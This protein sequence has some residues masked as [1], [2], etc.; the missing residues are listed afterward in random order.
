MP[1]YNLRHMQ[2]QPNAAHGPHGYLLSTIEHILHASR[3]GI[4]MDPRGIIKYREEIPPKPLVALENDADKSNEDINIVPKADSLGELKEEKLIDEENKTAIENNQLTT[5]ENQLHKVEDHPTAGRMKP[6]TEEKETAT[7]EHRPKQTLKRKLK[8]CIKHIFQRTKARKEYKD[9]TGTD[10]HENNIN[11]KEKNIEIK[12][13]PAL[14]QTRDSKVVPKLEVIPEQS[15]EP[16]IGPNKREASVQK[17]V[18]IKETIDEGGRMSEKE[19]MTEEFQSEDHRAE[20]MT[21][22]QTKTPNLDLERRV[23]R[24]LTGDEL[25]AKKLSLD[26]DTSLLIT[27][28]SMVQMSVNIQLKDKDAKTRYG[29][30]YVPD[31]LECLEVYYDDSFIGGSC[32]KINPADEYSSDHRQIRLFHCDFQCEHSLIVCVVTKNLVGYEEQFLNVKLHM[33]DESGE[34]LQVILIGRDVSQ[35][36]SGRGSGVISHVAPVNTAA[37]EDFRD[38]QK[39]MLLHQP[40]FYVPVENSYNWHVR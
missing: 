10:N 40:G 31:E 39:Y 11:I 2:Y 24:S 38:V 15:S 36:G 16:E 37:G 21:E 32:L 22:W 1:W 23:S 4:L 33:T 9:D 13:Q 14:L 19:Q 34:R 28:R 26:D 12:D 20:G 17:Q 25:K 30:A 18:S 6:T 7:E 5:D 3:T 8:S 27:G 35:L 29:L